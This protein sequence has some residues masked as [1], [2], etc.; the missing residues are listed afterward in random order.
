MFHFYFVG[1]RLLPSLRRRLLFNGYRHLTVFCS[2]LTVIFSFLYTSCR[3]SVVLFCTELIVILPSSSVQNFMPCFVMYVCISLPSLPSDVF[4]HFSRCRFSSELT[5]FLYP[6]AFLS[7]P[8]SCGQLL[9]L[10]VCPSP[11]MF[12]CYLMSLRVSLPLLLFAYMYLSSFLSIMSLY[13]SP[14][15]SVCITLSVPVCFPASASRSC[16]RSYSRFCL[17]Q[18]GQLLF[19]R[20]VQ[21]SLSWNASFSISTLFKRPAVADEILHIVLVSFVSPSFFCASSSSQ[22]RR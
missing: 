17:L 12:L 14:F 5:A 10:S 7:L 3:H 2:T 20:F 6:F 18:F 13:L 9:I 1:R 21:L 22:C 15:P 4:R 16:C 8:L 19:L 11:S